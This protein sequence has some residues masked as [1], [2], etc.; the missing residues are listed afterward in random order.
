[1]MGLQDDGRCAH[2]GWSVERLAHLPSG[3]RRRLVAYVE[4]Q[5]V[6]FELSDASSDIVVLLDNREFD[7]VQQ[8]FTVAQSLTS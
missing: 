5:E 3:R 1:M 2:N 4:I 8:P 7:V 6:Y